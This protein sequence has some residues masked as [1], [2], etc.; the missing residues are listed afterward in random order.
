MVIADVMMAETEKENAEEP[1]LFPTIHILQL[2]KDAR[3]RHGLRHADYNRYRSYCRSKLKHVRRALKFTNIHKCVRRHKAKFMKRWV[4]DETFTDEKFVQL[5]LFEAERRWAKAMSDKMAMEDN[6]DKLRKRHSLRMNLKRA[7]FHATS[8]ETLVRNNTK[9]DAP[10]KLEAQAYAA[11]LRGICCFELRKWHEAAEALKAAR[12][13]YDRLAEA[14]QN[15]TLANLYKAKCREIQ[16]QLRLCEFS[17]AESSPVEMLM[18]ELIAIRMQ[19]TDSDTV[20]RL[21]AEMRSKAT[22]DSVVV[23]EWGGF[24]STIEDNKTRQVIQG[25]KQVDTELNQCHTPKEKIALYEKQLTDTRDALDRMSDL[26]RRKAAENSDL[27]VLQSV[28]TYLEFL[29]MT[30]TSAKY[31]AM[32]ENIKYIDTI[33][34]DVVLYLS[35][36]WLVVIILNFLIFQIIELTGASANGDLI[37]AFRFKIEFYKTFRYVFYDLFPT[38]SYFSTF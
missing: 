17:S 33:E 2:V 32:I 5:G 14:T 29:K 6:P 38:P 7:V 18:N 36:S 34:W 35:V 24:K 23:I 1:L 10:T 16:P 22:S 26:I 27:S 8:L 20:D 21:I 11:W 31:L 15:T 28:K 4:I 19:G 3:Q 13:V 30:G 37:K 9:C 25:W 12:I